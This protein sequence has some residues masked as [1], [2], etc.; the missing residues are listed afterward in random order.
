[1]KKAIIILGMMLLII[2]SCGE[3]SENSDYVV[4]GGNNYLPYEHFIQDI[5]KGNPA[6]LTIHTK[7]GDIFILSSVVTN[8]SNVDIEMVIQKGGGSSIVFDV[9]EGMNVI[10]TQE[11]INYFRDMSNLTGEDAESFVAG[12]SVNIIEEMFNPESQICHGGSIWDIVQ[13]AKVNGVVA[14]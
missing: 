4:I 13:G 14:Q 2:S 3:V 6:D 9:Y 1:M 11:D 12:L 8:E 10:C 5:S 7:E